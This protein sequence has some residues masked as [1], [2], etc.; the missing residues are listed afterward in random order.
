MGTFLS[1]KRTWAGRPL[2]NMDLNRNKELHFY[3]SD[4]AGIGT[5]KEPF[6]LLGLSMQGM[7]LCFSMAKSPL[8]K[9]S[10]NLGDPCPDSR[11]ARPRQ[12]PYACHRAA[13]PLSLCLLK[14][15]AVFAAIC[16]VGAFPVPSIP[17][18]P[19]THH[20][21][22]L[23]HPDNPFASPPPSGHE[24]VLTDWTPRPNS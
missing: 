23:S 3:L 15:G 18:P 16:H 1:T 7:S 19:T 5:E 20:L 24:T 4:A 14:L 12:V 11:P 9:N 22:A 17:P 8:A 13:H 6:G 10:N 2:L 21:D